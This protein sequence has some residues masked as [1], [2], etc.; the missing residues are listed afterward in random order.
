MMPRSYSQV[1][2]LLERTGKASTF[3]EHR[4]FLAFLRIGRTA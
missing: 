1:E 2:E 3:I 4:Q